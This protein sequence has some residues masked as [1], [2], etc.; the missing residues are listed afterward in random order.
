MG[1]IAACSFDVAGLPGEAPDGGVA[2]VPDSGVID[3]LDGGSGWVPEAIPEVG[4]AL[5]EPCPESTPNGYFQFLDGTCGPRPTPSHV[6]RNR[7]CLIVD[8]GVWATLA[9]GSMVRYY[10]SSEPVTVN[11]T[12]LAGL[13]PEDMYIAVIQI[14]RVDGVPHYRYLGN[15]G[16]AAAIQ[17]WSTSKF[18]A[19][20]NAAAYM[21]SQSSYMVG[22]TSSVD[23]VQVGDLI[24]SMVNYDEA[25]FT[26][27]SLGRYF[28]DIGGRDRADD[29]IHGDWLHRPDSESFGGNYGDRAPD[30]GFT[31]SDGNA[32][33]DV[34][35]DRSRGPSNRLSMLTMAEAL[36]RLVLHRE[37]PSQRLPAIQWLDISMLLH[38]APVSNYGPWGGMS[39]DTAVYMHSGHDMDYI[40]RRSRGRWSIYSK[41]GLGSDGQFLNVG[42][43]CMPVLD[44]NL[45]PVPGWGREFIIAAALPTGGDSWADRD[46]NLAGIY[47]KIITRIV[48]G[49]L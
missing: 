49:R 23:G 10:D 2:V 42:Y 48:D 45:N 5:P 20:A 31:F 25:M 18:L 33:L 44:P 3:D 12:A 26:S 27:N 8:R 46:R 39:A 17:P 7:A 32:E 4:D 15:G 37:E 34:S 24:T 19:A 41:L 14:R 36:K 47:R 40:E 11:E 9:D 21:R 43:A 13:V 6:D 16:H 38:G 22:L 1:G 35:P 30:L 28:H 29:M